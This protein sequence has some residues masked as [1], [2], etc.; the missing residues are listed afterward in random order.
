MEEAEAG[1]DV[2][3]RTAEEAQGEVDVVDEQVAGDAA[4]YAS[5]VGRVAE[6]LEVQR[7]P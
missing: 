6:R 1:L 3:R 2:R 4:A 5:D 7:V